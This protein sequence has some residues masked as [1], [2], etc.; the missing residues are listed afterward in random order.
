MK[1]FEATED[2][3]AKKKR[4]MEKEMTKIVAVDAVVGGILDIAHC[5]D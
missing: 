1:N 5:L 2:S 3:V 4:A